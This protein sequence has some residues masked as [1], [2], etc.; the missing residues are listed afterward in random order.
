LSAAAA[1]RLEEAWAF[2]QK[3]EHQRSPAGWRAFADQAS[4]G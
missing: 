1:A 4:V 3:L 2:L